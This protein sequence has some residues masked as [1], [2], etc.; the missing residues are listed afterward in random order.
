LIRLLTALLLCFSV[1]AS[2]AA[3]WHVRTDGN[4]ANTGTGDS[5]GAAWRNIDFAADN[6]SV[7]AGDR[8]VVHA[9]TYTE[10]V[11]PGRSGSA[12]NPIK[13]VADGVVQ[14]DGVDLDSTDSYLLFVGFIIDATTTGAKQNGVINFSGT[15][16]ANIEFWHCEIREG[17][18]NAFRTGSGEYSHNLIVI[19]CELH[20]FGSGG[21][22][23]AVGVEGNDHFFMGNEI[24]DARPDAVFMFGQ[25]QRHL[26]YYIHGLSESEGGH[27]DGFQTGSG[28]NTLGWGFCLIEGTFH[29]GGGAGGDEHYSNFSYGQGASGP[30]GRNVFRFELAH[31]YGSGGLGVNQTTSGPIT[32]IYVYNRTGSEYNRQYPT[33][34][35]G[36]VFSD[37]QT[38]RIYVKNNIFYETW[39]T[40]ATSSLEVFLIE[41]A[42]TFEYDYNLAF[43]PD[44]SVTFASF[45]TSQANE[46]SNVDPQLNDVLNLIFTI[47]D[48]SGARNNGGW[49]TGVTGSGTSATFSVTNAGYFFGDN[50]A[51]AQYS[52]NLVVGDTITVGTDTIVIA[53][54][55][56]NDITATSSFTFAAGDKVYFGGDTTPDIGAYPHGHTKL[57]SATYTAGGVVTPNS[58]N[59]RMVVQFRDGVPFAVDNASPYEFSHQA[60]DVYRAY[61]GPVPSD[62]LWVQATEEGGG[63]G[64]PSAPA[65]KSRIRGIRL[66]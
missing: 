15:T 51:I 59:T 46:Q 55:S 40:S 26:N 53:S 5:A 41:D 57:T 1:V 64:E 33:V 18:F 3:T 10:I 16:T 32:N 23:L 58:S 4:N 2:H 22:G 56:G 48:S 39:G 20:D 24:Y 11:T 27:S 9:G 19:G 17:N 25:R 47:G 52:G 50:T 38:D 44:G 45:W 54:I 63:G 65:A 14:F 60:G 12:G 30:M 49:L 28:G 8:I 34:R 35:Y 66:R 21:S 61:A 43:D 36:D 13:F 37:A 62:T 29:V 6:G 7:S 31:N 42:T